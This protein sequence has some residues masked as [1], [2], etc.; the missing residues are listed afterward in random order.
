MEPEEIDKLFKNKFSNLPVPPAADAWMRL[1]AKMEPPKKERTMWIYYAAA[2]VIILLVSGLLLFRNYNQQPT[3][4]VAQTEVK[5]P[6]EKINLK[7]LATQATTP[8]ETS[9]T[10][11][12]AVI[13]QVNKEAEVVAK[14]PQLESREETTP[15]KEVVRLAQVKPKVTGKKPGKEF[16]AATQVKNETGN[17]P[18]LAVQNKAVKAPE[19][20]SMAAENEANNQ[21]V[22]VLVKQDN[23]GDAALAFTEDANLR[24]S[25]S[26]K[27]ALLKNIY[28]QARN[29]KNGEPVELATLGLDTEKINAEKENIKQKLN[30][31]ISL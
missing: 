25:I 14:E 28:K 27:G 18:A 10:S 24:E 6:L 15:K 22:Q 17:A 16:P 20:Q 23:T 31:V 8:P 30:K 4:T 7:N 2:S 9:S 1:Q 21:V 3:P 5:K 29:L 11:K 12:T 26:K 19:S 13:A